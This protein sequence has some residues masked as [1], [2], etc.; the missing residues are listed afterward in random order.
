MDIF[1]KNFLRLQADEKKAVLTSV[2]GDDWAPVIK[3]IAEVALPRLWSV[4]KGTKYAQKAL[5]VLRDYTG[6]DLNDDSAG[7]YGNQFTFN[8]TISRSLQWDEMSV[9]YNRES[10]AY[11]GVST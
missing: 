9:E 2:L 8:P 7:Q 10:R 4:L 11:D 1:G 3:G 5:R 6:I